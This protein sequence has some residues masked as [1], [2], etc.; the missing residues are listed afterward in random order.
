MGPLAH[1]RQKPR[2]KRF[3]PDLD[4]VHS[5]ERQLG[6]EGLWVMRSHLHEGVVAQP[7]FEQ[8]FGV[9]SGPRVADVVD[10]KDRRTRMP[11]RELLRL[12]H[13]TI[14]GSRAKTGPG[15]VQTA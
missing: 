9:A 5:R 7:S 4:V 14:G 12:G 11:G 8:L 1:L 13:D 6:P 10:E 15:T 3:D 2:R